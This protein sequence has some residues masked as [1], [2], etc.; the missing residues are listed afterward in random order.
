MQKSGL[1]YDKFLDEYV[2]EDAV[3]K[4]TTET[5]GYGITHLLRT[6]YSRIY[7]D[8]VNRYLR[9]PEGWRIVHRT[10]NARWSY[11]IELAATSE[12]T[13]R[14]SAAAADQATAGSVSGGASE[15]R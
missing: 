6:E 3:R 8:V 13:E 14:A 15:H 11:E 5:A 12:L 7:L 2:S 9:T 4:Y 10:A 1:L